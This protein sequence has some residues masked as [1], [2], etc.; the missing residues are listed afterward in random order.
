MERKGSCAG[1]QTLNPSGE[2]EEPEMFALPHEL[3][4]SLSSLP[5]SLPPPVE[6][7]DLLQVIT[8]PHN[9]STPIS[10]SVLLRRRDG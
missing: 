6:I 10:E 5:S 7:D 8:W 4:S 9:R 2:V 1:R 3:P